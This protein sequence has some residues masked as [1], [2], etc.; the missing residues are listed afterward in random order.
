VLTTTGT[1]RNLL[2]V[3]GFVTSSGAGGRVISASMD[4]SHGWAGLVGAFNSDAPPSA[5]SKAWISGA[6]VP[7]HRRTWNPAAGG[8]WNA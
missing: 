5:T 7:T 1:I 4:A 2:M 8:S 6:W 3:W